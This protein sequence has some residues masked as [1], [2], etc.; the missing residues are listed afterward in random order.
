MKWTK[1]S[2]NPKYRSLVKT[3]AFYTRGN[4]YY[5]TRCQC[6][7]SVMNNVDLNT[8]FHIRRIFLIRF[9]ILKTIRDDL[10][11]NF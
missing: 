8:L 5:L 3:K 11:E 1:S 7:G 9:Q 4:S 2:L 6:K 10:Y